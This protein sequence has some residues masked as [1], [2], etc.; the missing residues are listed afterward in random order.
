MEIEKILKVLS[1][2]NRLRILNMLEKKN[3]CVCEIT[4]I[5]GIKQ[6]SVSR[7][8]KKLKM[9]EKIKQQLQEEKVIKEDEKKLK[10]V[11]RC[12]IKCK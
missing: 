12:K 9:W 3:L 10:K 5:L 1:D 4:E 7:H 11:D 2:K 8:L 6:P